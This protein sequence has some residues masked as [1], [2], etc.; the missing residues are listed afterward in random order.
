[1]NIVRD[2]IAR[3]DITILECLLYISNLTSCDF[4]LFSKLKLM[5]REKCYTPF[6]IHIKGFNRSFEIENN[7]FGRIKLRVFNLWKDLLRCKIEIFSKI[8][9][10]DFVFFATVSEA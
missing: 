4:W 6:K 5:M 8:E 10:H 2:F 9:A 7:T 1:M 3:K